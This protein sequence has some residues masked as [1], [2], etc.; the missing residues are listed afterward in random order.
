MAKKPKGKEKQVVE[1]KKKSETPKE[2]IKNA[3]APIPV[4]VQVQ[5]QKEL[6]VVREEPEHENDTTAM[7]QSLSH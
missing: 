2:P 1:E 7:G 3:S 6:E 5:G 4:P